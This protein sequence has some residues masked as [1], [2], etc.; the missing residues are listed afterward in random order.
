MPKWAQ[1]DRRKPLWRRTSVNSA[2]S[3]CMTFAPVWSP[4][5][6]VFHNVLY[7]YQLQ[8]VVSHC[9]NVLMMMQIKEMRFTVV[10]TFWSVIPNMTKKGTEIVARLMQKHFVNNWSKF[11]VFQY[12]PTL[13]VKVGFLKHL[14][15]FS[16]MMVKIFADFSCLKFCTQVATKYWT[17]SMSVLKCA[18]NCVVHVW[19]C[20]HCYFCRILLMLSIPNWAFLVC[21]LLQKLRGFLF[22]VVRHLHGNLIGTDCSL[23]FVRKLSCFVFQTLHFTFYKTKPRL[24]VW[25]GRVCMFCCTLMYSSVH[26]GVDVHA[27]A[28]SGDN[29]R[30]VRFGKRAISSFLVAFRA[31]DSEV[32]AL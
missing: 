20:F 10:K 31:G 1:T 32:L 16:K 6:C 25:V 8:F 5:L 24:R 7:Q 19:F 11:I 28:V 9:L 15:S 13:Q 23:R 26:H 22:V 21:D 3:S 29:L 4:L 12:H 17:N 27:V 2:F 30:R 14:S 18:E